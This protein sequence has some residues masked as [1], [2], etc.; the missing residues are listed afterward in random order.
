MA[1]DANNL[2]ERALRSLPVHVQDILLANRAGEYT[3]IVGMSGGVDS[4]VSAYLLREAGFNVIGVFIKT[5]Q[6]EGMI[7]TWKDDRRDAMR[8]CAHLGIPFHTLDLEDEY[9]NHVADY[10][11]SEYSKGRT[12]NP[13]IM[14][15]KYVKFGGF[16]DFALE[17]NADFVATGHY[18]QTRNVHKNFRSNI[19][20]K[21]GSLQPETT[22]YPTY[23]T[24]SADAVKDQTYFLW[25]IKESQLSQTLFPVGGLRKEEVR[26]IAE[27]AE[28]PVFDKK[29]SQG[30]CFVGALDMKEFLK[31]A[32]KPKPGNVLDGKR[33]VIGTHEGVELYT[34]GERHGFTVFNQHTESEPRFIISKD[35]TANTL[36]VGSEK[37]LLK[38]DASDEAELSEVNFLSKNHQLRTKLRARIRH[39]QDLQDIQVSPLVEKDGTFR[40]KIK[41]KE[42]Q[43]GLASGQS[44]VLYDGDICLGG[45]II[46]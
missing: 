41:F 5:W 8:V 1:P 18:A 37:E 40:L 10:M 9:K 22:G 44:C 12:P 32:I 3:V 26:I 36:T 28:L 42:A 45:G 33:K 46:Q 13:D 21:S 43:K 7:C 31:D 25:A 29:D 23:L 39:R 35:M 4:S 6:P 2:T 14:C 38:S 15:N 16:F 34:I 17:H 20:S 30:V 27:H 24:L 19:N 11:I